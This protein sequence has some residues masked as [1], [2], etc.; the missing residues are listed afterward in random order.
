MQA[1]VNIR[2]PKQIFSAV[3]NAAASTFFKC[4][5]FLYELL[6]GSV[7]PLAGTVT[8]IYL[9]I[10]S[11]S[12]LDVIFQ[13]ADKTQTVLLLNSCEDTSHITLCITSSGSSCADRT[14]SLIFGLFS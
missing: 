9:R 3:I 13:I 4:S 6:D 7:A 12:F 11:V 2:P 5:H 1:Y 14:L 8:N 10:C